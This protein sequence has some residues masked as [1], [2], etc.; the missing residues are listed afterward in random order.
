LNPK[1][2]EAHFNLGI[3]YGEK[4]MFDEQIRE[5]KKAI[6]L[7]PRYAKAYKNLESSYRQMGMQK[8]ADKEL[9]KY[10]DL[11]RK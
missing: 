2:A 5:Y 4:R 6:E 1:N 10:N 3:V 7:N 11:V 8:E 9:S